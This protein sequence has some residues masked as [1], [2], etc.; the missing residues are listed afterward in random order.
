MKIC[1]SIFNIVIRIYNCCWHYVLMLDCSANFKFILFINLILFIN[2][3]KF[4][5]MRKKI[6]GL[7]LLIAPCMLT[8][9]ISLGQISLLKS[10]ICNSVVV[11]NSSEHSIH[12]RFVINL[13]QKDDMERWT[14]LRSVVVTDGE[15]IVFEE[16]PNGEYRAVKLEFTNYNNDRNILDDN[17]SNSVKL[18]CLSPDIPKFFEVKITPNPANT[19]IEIDIDAISKQNY[20]YKISNVL[21]NE[22]IES[23]YQS[24][25]IDITTL[26]EGQY[27]IHITSDGF[28]IGAGRFIK[29]KN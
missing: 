22:I 12:K 28:V 20:M 29:I 15:E 6:F 3:L 8:P 1:N 10:N 16:I 21:G 25:T 11:K 13:E 4:I 17:T 24:S 14:K 2:F 19:A 23:K 26:E 5:I 27:M 7:C 18:D 9:N